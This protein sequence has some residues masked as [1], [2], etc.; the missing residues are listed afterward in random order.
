[1]NIPPDKLAHLQAGAKAS[2]FGAACGAVSGYLLAGLFGDV[3]P[4]TVVLFA[5]VSAFVA[6]LSAGATKELADRADNVLHPG[7]RSVEVADAIFT[8]AGCVPVELALL[9]LLASGFV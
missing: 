5:S 2:L 1:M 7:S 9:A 8:A 6:S 4:Q 3:S